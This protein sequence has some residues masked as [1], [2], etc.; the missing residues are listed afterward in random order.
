M[1]G[2]PSPSIGGPRVL[3]AEAIL[4]GDGT[5]IRDGALVLD[6]SGTVLDLGPAVDVLARSTGARVEARSGVILPGL[7]NAHVHLELSA[8]RGKTTGGAG[9]VPWLESLQRA[10]ASEGEDEHERSAA[11]DRAIAGLVE[12]GVVAVGE[13]SNGL[14]AWAR[15][16][17]RLLGTVFHE[18]FAI[19]RATGL[20][21]LD[22]LEV[23]RDAHAPTGGRAH[24]MRWVPVPHALYSTHPDVVRAL[25]ARVGADSP[26]TMHLAEHA[27]ERA[28]LARGDGPWRGFLDRRGLGAAADAFPIDGRDPLALAEALGVLRPGAAMVHLADARP[29]ELDRMASHRAI[30]VLC[31]RSNL[32]I[33]T[34]LPPLEALRAR[35]VELALGTDSLASAPS[36]DPLGDARALLE[37]N[38]GCPAATLVCAAT[39]GGARAIGWGDALGRLAVGTRPG[40]LHVAAPRGLPPDVD[41]SAWLLRADAP[42]VLLAAAARRPS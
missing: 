7:V 40:V 20:A 38:P 29:E 8:L 34:K 42:R 13:V 32:T 36:L 22:T 9:F 15:A 6:E 12:V 27:A 28:F 39:S 4:V 33:E 41:P 3:R 16:S 14:G 30:A 25:V 11:I 10:R 17:E 35:G 18:V 1:T 19:D 31:P 21:Q 2:G 5:T 23:Q 37:R 24:A 26:I